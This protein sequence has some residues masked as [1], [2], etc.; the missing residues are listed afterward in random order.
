LAT[1]LPHNTAVDLM[2]C[3]WICATHEYLGGMATKMTKMNL[4]VLHCCI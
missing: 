4:Q 2:Y 3:D 1:L